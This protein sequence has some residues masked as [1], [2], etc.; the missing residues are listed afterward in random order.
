MYKIRRVRGLEEATRYQEE[1]K[2]Y[3][4]IEFPLSYLRRS[5]I[6]VIYNSKQEM[7]G[8]FLIVMEGP[9]RS[10]ES[11]PDLTYLPKKV[12]RWDVA[13]VNALWLSPVLRKNVFSVMFWLFVI[14]RLLLSGRKYFTYTYSTE[15]FKLKEFYSRANPQTIYQ[16]KTKALEGMAEEDFESIDIVSRSHIAMAPLKNISL[17]FKRVL[18]GRLTWSRQKKC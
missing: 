11:L 16:G 13:E 7:L 5:K 4:G 18:S 9:L 10:F 17:I 6:Y 2:K 8:G 3:I 12:D 14:S 1:A 15:K